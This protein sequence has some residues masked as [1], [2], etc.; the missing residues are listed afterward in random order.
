MYKMQVEHRDWPHKQDHGEMTLY[1][2]QELC[3][4]S[5]EDD[6]AHFLVP[7]QV[8]SLH[9]SPAIFQSSARMHNNQQEQVNK[10]VEESVKVWTT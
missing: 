1:R 5:L 4:I 2:G 8:T 6:C 9:I 10:I 3:T 7:I